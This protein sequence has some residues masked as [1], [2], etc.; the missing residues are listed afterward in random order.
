MTDEIN[1]QGEEV[2]A[3]LGQAM[4]TRKPEVLRLALR[5]AG[6]FLLLARA[7]VLH[8]SHEP[9]IITRVASRVRTLH[10]APTGNWL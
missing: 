7:D 3:A 8:G 2:L 10:L 6:E 9:S 1:E 5:L 4:R